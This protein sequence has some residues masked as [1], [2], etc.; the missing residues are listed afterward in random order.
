MEEIKVLNDFKNSIITFLDELID[1]FPLEA[2]LVIFRIF[3]KNQVPII[4]IMNMFIQKLLPFKEMIVTRNEDFFLNHCTLFDG[5]QDSNKKDSVNK[6][7]KIWRSGNLDKDDKEVIFK[8]FDSFIFLA[9][10]YQ[11]IIIKINLAVG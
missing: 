3:M 1:Q 8:W 2:D 4:D 11:K 6:F 5:M 9:E 7:K 10:K